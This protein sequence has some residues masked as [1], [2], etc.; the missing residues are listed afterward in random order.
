MFKLSKKNY[1]YL[2]LM[3]TDPSVAQW[4]VIDQTEL[5]RRVQENLL[6]AGA[7]LFRID[8]ELEVSFETKTHIK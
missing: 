1:R 3:P 5:D 2:Y 4:E 8:K 6:Q 7:K